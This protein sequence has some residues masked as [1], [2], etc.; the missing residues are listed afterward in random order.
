VQIPSEEAVRRRKQSSTGKNASQSG[1]A[2]KKTR[3][4]RLETIPVNCPHCRSALNIPVNQAGR[5]VPCLLC[6]QP[7]EV[8]GRF[9]DQ[10]KTLEL[11]R[12]KERIEKE[13]I[14][15]AKVENSH[16]D[17]VAPPE[18]PMFYIQG[19]IDFPIYGDAL[20]KWVYMSILFA[21]HGMLLDF[22]VW[23]LS[24]GLP[25]GLRALG[26]AVAFMTLLVGAYTAAIFQASLEGSAA[27]GHRY[28]AWYPF[29]YYGWL[30]IFFRYIYLF[31]VAAVI[32]F[33]PYYLAQHIEGYQEW[34]HSFQIPENIEAFK[35]LLY[36]MP[37]WGTV[38]F[39]CLPFVILSSL[40]QNE[41]WACF[42]PA[43]FKTLFR[44]WYAWLL[45]VLATW[46]M[47]PGLLILRIIL[48]NQL[49]FISGAVLAP[50]AAAFVMIYG[51]LLGRVGLRISQIR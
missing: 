38:T 46:I 2:A 27:G 19:I 9:G 33:V 30:A 16:F 5:T 14:K 29:D 18:G 7:I 4:R 21:L 31:A 23:A 42:S 35:G 40:E 36:V 22:A 51:R 41:F 48:T 25:A 3:S 17:D 24:E 45:L 44:Y 32:G 10:Q 50:F 8:P 1:A 6:E 47:F 39:A 28:T 15:P 12:E 37:V 11:K 43:V 26:P 34:L 49:P 13:T 20:S